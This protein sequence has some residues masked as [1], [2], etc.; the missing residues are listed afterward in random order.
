MEQGRFYA[1]SGVT[2][3]R[4]TTSSD[5]IELAAHPEPGV[6]YTIEFV[7]TRRGYNPA[8]EPVRDKDGKEDPRHASLQRRHRHRVEKS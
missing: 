4:V 3:D 8:S 2:L 6:T 1:S 7:G 5:G